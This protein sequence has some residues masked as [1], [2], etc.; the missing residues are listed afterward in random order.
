VF[1]LGDLRCGAHAGIRRLRPAPFPGP[2]PTA[3]VPTASP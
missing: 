1:T 3:S 2:T